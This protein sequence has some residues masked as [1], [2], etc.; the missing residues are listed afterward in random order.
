MEGTIRRLI[1][2]NNLLILII[3]ILSGLLV[4]TCYFPK[5]VETISDTPYLNKIDSLQNVIDEL[6]LK[7]DSIRI[8]IDTVYSE[9]LVNNTVYEENRNNIIDNT[10]N[11]DLEFFSEYVREQRPRLFSSNNF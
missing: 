11:E 5:T 3:I 8:E 7:K 1:K 9:I 6:E 4:L 2:K 10:V